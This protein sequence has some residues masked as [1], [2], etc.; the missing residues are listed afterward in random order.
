MAWYTTPAALA[1]IAQITAKPDVTITERRFP[2]SVDYL[3]DFAGPQVDALHALWKA[4]FKRADRSDHAR[5]IV[6]G[7]TYEDV[8]GALWG[9]PEGNQYYRTDRDK[10][11][12]WDRI[13]HEINEALAER[14]A[15]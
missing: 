10:S 13:R 12:G 2:R 7:T 4:A 15:A 8:I 1:I 9:D 5:A 6:L 3:Y 11:D 14:I